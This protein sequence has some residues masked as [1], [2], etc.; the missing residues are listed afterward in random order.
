MLRKVR[1][2]APEHM[3][4]MAN[5]KRKVG[6]RSA[7]AG[8][9]G[10]A[11]SSQPVTPD[12]NPPHGSAEG[13]GPVN[14]STAE[15]GRPD[16]H[17]GDGADEHG[18]MEDEILGIFPWSLEWLKDLDSEETGRIL[19]M[20][21]GVNPFCAFFWHSS[22]ETDRVLFISAVEPRSVLHIFFFGGGGTDLAVYM[23]YYFTVYRLYYFTPNLPCTLLWHGHGSRIKPCIVITV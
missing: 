2:L 3:R 14:A 4:A 8:A 1:T 7:G 18:S 10:A 5:T 6:K 11:E 15:W 12:L 21:H 13:A 22:M 9:S 17:N 19:H 16:D 23:L 20:F